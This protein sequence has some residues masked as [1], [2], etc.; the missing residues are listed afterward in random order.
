MTGEQPNPYHEGEHVWNDKPEVGMSYCKICKIGKVIL[1]YPELRKEVEELRQQLDIANN[2]LPSNHK[3]IQWQGKKIKELEAE[4]D[5]V[6]KTYQDLCLHAK[7]EISTL[8]D[9]LVASDTLYKSDTK[10]IQKYAEENAQLQAE[11]NSRK[12]M[13]HEE[14]IDG[15]KLTLK[16]VR[17]ENALMIVE[18]IIMNSFVY[19][20]HVSNN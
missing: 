1:T 15:L 14:M 7:E 20:L 3:E 18:G 17:E 10:K 5:E 16:G 6:I 8:K 12:F 19:V 13:T 2:I 4:K 11:L 9:A